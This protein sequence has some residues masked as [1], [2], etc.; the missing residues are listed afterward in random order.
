[1]K[2]LQ[3]LIICCL[4]GF[5]LSTT[6]C[7]K[8]ITHTKIEGRILEYGSGLPLEGAKVVLSR[9]STGNPNGQLHYSGQDT[10]ITGKDGCYHFD[11][12]HD[13]N[14]TLFLFVY[15]ENYFDYENDFLSSITTYRDHF[16]DPHA[17]LH[18]HV[19]NVN[20]V[21]D[22]DRIRLGGGGDVFHGIN[23]DKII[24]EKRR[25]NRQNDLTWYVEKNSQGSTFHQSFYLLA[26][27]TTYYEIFY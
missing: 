1:M 27:D 15:K 2:N 4:F 12:E 26:H 20:P 9:A 23:I 13:N 3:I 22:G 24:I 17:Y 8:E 16:I 19:K 5:L 21:D 10:L 14:S 7:E 11:F 6:S 25:G 18:L